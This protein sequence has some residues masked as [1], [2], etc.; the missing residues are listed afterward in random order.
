[1]TFAELFWLPLAL[2]AILVVVGAGPA[3][4]L[5]RG[6][7]RDVQAALA[8][9]CGCAVVAC[10]ADL[11]RLGAPVAVVGAI[12]V[13]FGAAAALA[14]ARPGLRMLAAGGWPLAAA[15]VALLLAAAPRAARGSWTASV[16]GNV[17]TYLWTS[18][19][20]A[21]LEGPGPGPAGLHPDRLAFDRI[22]EQGWA[23]A[24]PVGGALVALVSRSDAVGSYGAVAALAAVFLP[25]A[26]Y[27]VARTC[28]DWSPRWSAFGAALVGANAGL[29]HAGYFGWH[30]Q[31]LGTAF[32][33][34]A[35]GLLRRGLEEG[36]TKLLGLAGLMAAAALGSY[37]LP[38][39]PVV[40]LALGATVVGYAIQQRR[41]LGSLARRL[42]WFVAT[43]AVLGAGSLAGLAVGLSRFLTT[44][45]DEPA[46]AG[47]PR[48][49]VAEALGFL[50]VPLTPESSHPP[51]LTVA[52]ATAAAALL[53]GGVL[54]LAY[55]R[56]L[57]RRDFLTGIV[58]AFVLATVVLSLP[59]FSPY[60]STKL[61]AYAAPFLV[62]VA[63]T[64]FVTPTRPLVRPAGLI[65]LALVVASTAA[66]YDR[67]LQFLRTPPE[68]T[69]LGAAVAGLPSDA[70]VSVE[71]ADAWT[72]AWLFYELRDA[73]VSVVEPSVVLTGMGS[74]REP[75]LFRH[76]AAYA[77]DYE[78]GTEGLW[79]GAGLELVKV[80]P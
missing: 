38:F 13:G 75:D 50:P 41:E 61:L 24:L 7:P 78:S 80:S 48:G 15:S 58:G 1:V 26:V 34:A 52:A 73:A 70:V 28:L 65:A 63:L 51:V 5:G 20:R 67:G 71:I 30:G 17:D 47:L 66:V 9:L 62:L 79:S 53:V 57:P 33:V 22:A 11:V 43:F 55:R 25:L 14:V 59:P 18:Q 69:G 56:D 29:L 21:L 16:F 77:I 23:V 31:L 19:A 45:L 4:V 74:G 36:G 12:A 60:L 3:L 35:A 10:L 46:W 37:R 76:D 2:L 42:G 32:L 40:V 39:V 6:L 68:L 27:V 54:T 8:P 49:S 64:T 72:Q 44:Q